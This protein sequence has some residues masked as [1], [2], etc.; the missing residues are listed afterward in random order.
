MESLAGFRYWRWYDGRLMPPIPEELEEGRTL[1]LNGA[2]IVGN[3]GN[4]F[5]VEQASLA[6]A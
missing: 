2:I 4:C 6:C 3:K 5:T 1:P